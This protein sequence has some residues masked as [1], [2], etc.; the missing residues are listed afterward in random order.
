M[1][2]QVRLALAACVALSAASAQAQ[3]VPGI[4]ICTVEKTMERRTSCLQSNVDFLKKSLD[5]AQ[6]DNRTRDDA[7]TRQIEALKLAI[8]SL[9]KTVTDLQVEVERLKKP[10]AP[11]PAAGA[12]PAAPSGQK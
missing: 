8:V 6:L 7:A 11:P 12:T 5:K 4:E 3:D 9:Q 2:F 10:A 1:A